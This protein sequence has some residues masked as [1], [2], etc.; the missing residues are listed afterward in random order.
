MKKKNKTGLLFQRM[1]QCLTPR[2]THASKTDAILQLCVL[3]DQY[4]VMIKQ[5]AC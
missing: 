3:K 4:G 2:L 5:H 1:N